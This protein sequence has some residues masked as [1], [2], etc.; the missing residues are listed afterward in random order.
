MAA[1]YAPPVHTAQP[2]LVTQFFIRIGL[3]VQCGRRFFSPLFAIR[4]GFLVHSA[5]K[6]PRAALRHPDELDVLVQHS[7]DQGGEVDALQRTQR[8]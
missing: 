8:R 6:V 4:I 3:K 1:R 7:I 2:T 5:P